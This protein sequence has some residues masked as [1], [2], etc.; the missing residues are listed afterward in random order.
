M[1]CISKT[2]NFYGKVYIKKLVRI[3]K[4]TTWL[5]VK[6]IAIIVNWNTLRNA[7][8]CWISKTFAIQGKNWKQIT[9]PIFWLNKSAKKQ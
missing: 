5:N 6:C 8:Y 9:S 2:I 3:L 4:W 1:I 7:K